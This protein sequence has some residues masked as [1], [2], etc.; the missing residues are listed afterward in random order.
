MWDSS[1]TVSHI[2]S[3]VLQIETVINMFTYCGH[4][5]LLQVETTYE[6]WSKVLELDLYLSS[7]AQGKDV[8]SMKV[9]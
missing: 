7:I 6:V 8:L 2:L 1:K 3:P 9:S 4:S 5:Y